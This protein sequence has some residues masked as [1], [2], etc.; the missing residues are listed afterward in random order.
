MIQ[1]TIDGLDKRFK[2]FKKKCKLIFAGPLN[3]VEEVK[4]ARLRLLWLGDK[5]LEICNMS[6]WANCKGDNLKI[7]PVMAAQETYTK[8]EHNQAFYK[9]LEATRKHNVSLN[10]EKLQF[11]QTQVNFFGHIPTEDGI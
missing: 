2:L 8:S 7:A 9:M 4:K 5:G 11:K 1:I 3:K 6:T 10:S